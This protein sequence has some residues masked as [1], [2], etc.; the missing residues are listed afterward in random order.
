[1]LS[2]QSN[3]YATVVYSGPLHHDNPLV[4]CM[5]C[6]A[7]QA[8]AVWWSPDRV[9]SVTS[10]IFSPEVSPADSSHT[11]KPAASA[12]EH[13]FYLEGFPFSFFVCFVTL[14]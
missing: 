11:A 8:L 7:P 14:F 1:M 10:D 5:P 13:P 3:F 2:A 9:S 12:P 6:A 4:A